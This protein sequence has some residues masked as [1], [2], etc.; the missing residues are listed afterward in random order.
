[1]FWVFQVGA[2]FGVCAYLWLLLAPLL[3]PAV[4]AQ[5]SQQTEVLGQ[6]H[7]HFYQSV[8]RSPDPAKVHELVNQRRIEAGLSTLTAS[9][10]LGELAHKRAADMQSADYY[11][12]ENPDTGKTFIDG[13]RARA[14]DYRF[15][16]E[17]LN[18]AFSRRETATIKAW[19][20][21]DNGHRECMLHAT[22]SQAGYA[23]VDAPSF[24]DKE[25]YI[26]VAIYAS[27]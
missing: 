2:F 22:L 27:L 14:V 13:L 4:T 11:A 12:H 23:V 6:S 25:S 20:D 9:A 21:S 1:M 3:N 18:L 17:N 26:I 7:V 19:L 24:N 5:H 10:T 15:T 16:C 8:E